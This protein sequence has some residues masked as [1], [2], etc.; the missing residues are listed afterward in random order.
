MKYLILVCLLM[1]ISFSSLAKKGDYYMYLVFYDGTPEG[2]RF[3]TKMKSMDEC[4]RAMKS[5]IVNYNVQRMRGENL[6]SAMWCGGDME[7]IY[8]NPRQDNGK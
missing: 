3:R 1:T 2:Q 7:K 8:L 5:S 4:L 6:T